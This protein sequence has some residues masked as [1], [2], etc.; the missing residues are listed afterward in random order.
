MSAEEKKLDRKRAEN[1]S[2]QSVTSVPDGWCWGPLTQWADAGSKG[3]ATQKIINQSE[4]NCTYKQINKCT[5]FF[6][7]LR[8]WKDLDD[9]C[10]LG[11]VSECCRVM[12]R[13]FDIRARAAFCLPWLIGKQLIQS[14]HISVTN[15][16]YTVISNCHSIY[17]TFNQNSNIYQASSLNFHAFVNSKMYMATIKRLFLLRT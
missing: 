13:M 9:W 2:H 15:E 5:R 10:C 14:I 4:G 17:K 3:R 16:C 6:V 11:V 7:H 8:E 1:D 12:N